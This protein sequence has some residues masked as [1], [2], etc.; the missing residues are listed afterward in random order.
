MEKVPLPLQ[1][2]R[3][4]VRLPF[5]LSITILVIIGRAIRR[6]WNLLVSMGA[7]PGNRHEKTKRYQE[8]W[9]G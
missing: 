2:G 3:A 9:V 5:R 8:P 1:G 7:T 4:A 6:P